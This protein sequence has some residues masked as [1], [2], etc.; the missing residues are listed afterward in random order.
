MLASSWWG[1]G[2][3]QGWLTADLPCMQ[4]HCY[5]YILL[6]GNSLDALGLVDARLHTG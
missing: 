1:P 6:R 5:S 2:G 3:A 4:H